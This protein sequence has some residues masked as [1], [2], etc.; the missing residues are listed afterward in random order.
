MKQNVN[1]WKEYQETEEDKKVYT[2][3]KNKNEENKN[4]LKP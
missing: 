2:N 1:K 4:N 3:I